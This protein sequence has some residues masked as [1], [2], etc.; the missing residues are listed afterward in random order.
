MQLVV[1]LYQMEAV[2]STSSKSLEGG[3]ISTNSTEDDV[4]HECEYH[5]YPSRKVTVSHRVTGVRTAWIKA[6]QDE[7]GNGRVRSIQI[8][9]TTPRF[10]LYTVHDLEE[11][12]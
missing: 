9:V 2:P 1:T 11:G 12:H 8:T 10:H 4:E 5:H 3:R 7:A 6:M